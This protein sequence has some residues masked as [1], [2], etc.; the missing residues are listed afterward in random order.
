MSEAFKLQPLEIEEYSLENGLRVVLNKDDAIP[1]VSVAVYYNVGSRNERPDRTGFAHLFEHMMFQGSKNYSSDYLSAVLDMGAAVNGNTTT[2]RTFYYE[3][4]PSNFLERALYLE[5]DRMGGLLEAMDQA[6]LDN[7]RDVVKNERRFRVDNVPYGG[8]SERILDVM[9]PE[10][11]PY[12]WDVIGSMADLS[13]ASLDDVKSFFRTYYVPN[14]TYMA[15]SGDFD[16]KQ[17]MAWINKYFGKIPA[18]KAIVRPNVPEPQLS[19]IVRKTYEDPF[20]R[21]P[22]IALVWPSVPQYAPDEAPLDILAS[23]LSSGRGSRLQ[24]NLVYKNELVGNVFAGNSTSEIAGL[25]QITATA[26]QGKPIDDIE[27][28]INGEIERIKKDGPTAEE[29]GRAITQREAQAIYGLQTVFGIG[30][31]LASYSGYLGQ[32]NYFQANLD[33]YRKV[34]PDEVKGVANKYLIANHLVLTATPAK[35]PPPPAQAGARNPLKSRG[36]VRSGGANSVALRKRPRDT[37]SVTF[38]DATFIE[39][40]RPDRRRR[41]IVEQDDQPASGVVRP[42]PCRLPAC[43]R[44]AAARRCAPS[45]VWRRFSRAHRADRPA[46]RYLGGGS[47]RRWCRVSLRAGLPPQR[48]RN[49]LF[50]ISASVD[51]KNYVEVLIMRRCRQGTA[52]GLGLGGI[53]PGRHGQAGRGR[54]PL[55]NRRQGGRAQG[56][57]V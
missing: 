5:A 47:S 31:A 43:R 9:Y 18:G 15:I 38:G 39:S 24:S 1:V 12:R 7:Q 6:K 32:P 11:H 13:A 33:R 8:M 36:L 27:R 4:V 46:G 23:V 44:T 45:D 42:Q 53:D 20:A 52:F 30:T 57:P 16:E 3:V 55:G 50:L 17:T 48:R 56:H 51:I 29:V 54:Q 25:F 2:D 41:A 19:S 35:T 28:E 10:G 26:R 40:K 21:Q 14:N 22:R 34:T 37:S 49:Q